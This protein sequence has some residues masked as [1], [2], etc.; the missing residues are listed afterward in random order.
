MLHDAWA[1][2]PPR[3]S[4]SSRRMM[5]PPT[6]STTPSTPAAHSSERP[7]DAAVRQRVRDRAMAP[8]KQTS[9]S[10]GRSHART[11]TA[12]AM[13]IVVSANAWSPID[14]RV[15]DT[16]D[17][18]GARSGATTA[19]APVT[20]AP[21][22]ARRRAIESAS[23]SVSSRWVASAAARVGP[24]KR[25]PPAARVATDS[26]SGLIATRLGF[27]RT[28]S[29]EIAVPSSAA[30]ASSRRMSSTLSAN[31]GPSSTS[32]LTWPASNPRA[33]RTAPRITR[34]RTMIGERTRSAVHDGHRSVRC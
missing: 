7:T 28:S 30:T 2:A 9:A 32:R 22:S 17:D 27:W 6:T 12:R 19:S 29:L 8:A 31:V 34:I 14:A 26:T 11:P 21:T 24:D 23:P 5:K 18:T 33:A 20:T 15:T 3:L 16:S 1:T 10:T 25:S 13:A 4:A